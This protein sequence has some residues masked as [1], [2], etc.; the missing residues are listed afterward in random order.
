MGFITVA[1]SSY[2]LESSSF[3]LPWPLW[4]EGTKRVPNLCHCADGGVHLGASS[5]VGGSCTQTSPIHYCLSL[6][7]GFSSGLC[8]IFNNK[9]D[10]NTNEAK[11]TK[12]KE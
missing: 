8:D 12:S 4:T 3:G 7:A 1:E 11:N 2:T 5:A 9:L 10:E 6:L